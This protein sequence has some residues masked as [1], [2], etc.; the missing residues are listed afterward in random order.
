MD[1][2]V[3]WDL[4]LGAGR[5]SQDPKHLRLWLTPRAL[6]INTLEAPQKHFG[7]SF[8]LYPKNKRWLCPNATKVCRLPLLTTE[9]DTVLEYRKKFELWKHL[10]KRKGEITHQVLSLDGINATGYFL[11]KYYFQALIS[12]IFFRFNVCIGRHSWINTACKTGVL[13]AWGIFWLLNDSH[14]SQSLYMG[15]SRC[16]IHEASYSLPTGYLLN[17]RIINSFIFE[18]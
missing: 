11:T 4:T 6:I 13:A 16:N 18:I 5:V 7:P 12:T 9:I 10:S 3:T 2:S 1:S 15:N 14:Y 8:V 17:S